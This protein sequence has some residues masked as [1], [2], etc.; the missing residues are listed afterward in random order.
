[1]FTDSAGAEYKLY[2]G[3]STGIWTSQDSIYVTYDSNANI[4]HFND[5]SYWTMGCVSGG[6]EADLG[7]LYPTQMED[8][9]GNYVSI[10]YYPGAG[11][12][13]PN[14]S[15]RINTVQDVRATYQFSFDLNS[16]EL[17][18]IRGGFGGVSQT[19]SFTT[20]SGGIASP[21]S[22]QAYWGTANTLSSVTMVGLGTTGFAYNGS[23][24]LTQ[25]TFPKGGHLRYDYLTWNYL[26]PVTGQQRQIRE[27]SNRYLSI[28][29]DGS[30]EMK[31]PFGRMTD[32][33]DGTIGLHI[34][35]LIPDPSGVG[36]KVWFFNSYAGQPAWE[37]GTIVTLW[38]M[39]SFTNIT[40]PRLTNYTW[41]QDAAGNP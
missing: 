26:G 27:V 16:G 39:V 18:T 10:T 40:M 35:G 34:Y 1:M 31:Y 8:S 9:N 41:T 23:A 38:E 14:S 5:G 36:L 24:E 32:P 29:S 17:A 25:V 37:L 28:N 4:L 2:G 11:T 33:N 21:T 30:G 15:A 22:S 7:T 20:A 12:T 6:Q 19:Y 13:W 3:A